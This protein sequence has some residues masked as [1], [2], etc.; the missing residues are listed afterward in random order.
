MLESVDVVR[1]S[2][3]TYRGNGVTRNPY[4]RLALLLCVALLV[5][6]AYLPILSTILELESPEPSGWP[7]VL[8]LAFLCWSARVRAG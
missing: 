4:V 6:S 3:E 2:L 1:Q 5:G 8:V 7:V